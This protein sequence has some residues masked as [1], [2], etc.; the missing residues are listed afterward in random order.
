[1]VDFD[2]VMDLWQCFGKEFC[3]FGHDSFLQT[4]DLHNGVFNIYIKSMPKKVNNDIVIMIWS[5][6]LEV[7]SNLR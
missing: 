7:I 3:L 4:L 5:D 6:F 1:M 2:L